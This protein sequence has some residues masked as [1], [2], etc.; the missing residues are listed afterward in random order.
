MNSEHA[1]KNEFNDQIII[2]LDGNA[3]YSTWNAYFQ[4]NQ[5]Y[6]SGYDTTKMNIMSSTGNLICTLSDFIT[7]PTYIPSGAYLSTTNS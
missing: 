6:F 4:G 5:V 7:N 3:N 2:Y 1:A